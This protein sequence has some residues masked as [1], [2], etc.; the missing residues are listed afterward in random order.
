MLEARGQIALIRSRDTVGQQR[1]VRKG[2]TRA[3][4]AD[5]RKT[6]TFR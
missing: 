3:N 6:L 2:A 5:P 1:L 4:A